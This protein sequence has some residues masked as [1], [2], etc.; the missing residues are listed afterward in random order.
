M[1]TIAVIFDGGFALAENENEL[2]QS[3]KCGGNLKIKDLPDI[4]QAY[5]YACD[6]HCKSE[7][8]KYY[9]KKIYLP[10]FEDMI[11]NPI[12][13]NADLIPY[14][15]QAYRIF[16]AFNSNNVA[17]LD[18]L[19]AIISFTQQIKNFKIKE[20]ANPCEAQK[21]LDFQFLKYI[22]PFG[23]YFQTPIPRCPQLPLNTIVPVSFVQWVQDNLTPQTIPN[24][25]FNARFNNFYPQNVTLLQNPDYEKRLLD[26]VDQP[27]END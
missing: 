27:K 14:Q 15:E 11:N 25:I 9:G 3:L 19:D 2:F 17:I 4:E 12:F 8:W 23:A 18:N 24:D 22:L 1:R 26:M 13:R 7:Y 6:Q 5:L 10:R 16:A 20:V 21:Y